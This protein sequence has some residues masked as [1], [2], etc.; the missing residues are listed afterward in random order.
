M[1]LVVLPL[2]RSGSRS[3]GAVI[4]SIQLVT[5]IR[6]GVVPTICYSHMRGGYLRKDPFWNIG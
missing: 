2:M 5:D 6:M 3:Q 4:E 1:S